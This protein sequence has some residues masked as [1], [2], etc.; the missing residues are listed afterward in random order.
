MK[1]CPYLQIFVANSMPSPTTTLHLDL[2]RTKGKI[3]TATKLAIAMEEAFSLHVGDAHE[4]ATEKVHG[5]ERGQDVV[6]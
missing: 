2:L 5:R 6:F 1:L 3:C 4:V